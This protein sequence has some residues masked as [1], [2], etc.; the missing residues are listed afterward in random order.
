MML[1]LKVKYSGTK[2]ILRDYRISSSVYNDV[3]LLNDG[4]D[5]CLKYLEISGAH[6][7]LNIVL[8]QVM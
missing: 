3:S 8:E 5:Q 2:F 4:S 1:E 6:D 7:S